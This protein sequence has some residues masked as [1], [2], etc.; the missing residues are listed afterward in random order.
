[1]LTRDLHEQLII[2]PDVAQSTLL[3]SELSSVFRSELPTPESDRFVSDNDATLG[4]QILHVSKA[5][6]EAVIDNGVA[7]NFGRKTMA[8]IQ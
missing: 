1:M 7:D 3:L 6:W 2:V 5:E 4:Q 8:S